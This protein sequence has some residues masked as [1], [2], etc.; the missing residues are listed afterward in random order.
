M[1][2]KEKHYVVDNDSMEHMLGGGICST[3]KFA[4]EDKHYRFI[5]VVESDEEGNALKWSYFYFERRW[6]FDR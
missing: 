6:P 4:I 5:D 3:R 1:E 2:V